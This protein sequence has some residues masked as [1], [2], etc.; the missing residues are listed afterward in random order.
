MLLPFPAHRRRFPA[1]APDPSP[2][3][4]SPGTRVCITAGPFAGQ[5]ATVA[6]APGENGQVE[7]RL[8]ESGWRVGCQREV[9]KKAW[10]CADL[11]TM[12]VCTT[13]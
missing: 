2:D 12:N 5:T 6:R 1:I 10:P 11:R 3:A 7:I 9:L 4:L 13:L 8:D